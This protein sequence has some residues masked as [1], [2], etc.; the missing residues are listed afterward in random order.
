MAR[1]RYVYIVMSS[2][3]SIEEYINE[4]G[5]WDN[6]T[7]NYV[8]SVFGTEKRAKEAILKYKEKYGDKSNEKYIHEYWIK[9][10]EIE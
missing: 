3:T 7:S 5:E 4:Y 8:F 2:Y 1:K 9:K 10:M 6:D